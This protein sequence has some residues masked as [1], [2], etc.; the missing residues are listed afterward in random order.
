MFEVEGEPVHLHITLFFFSKIKCIK[1][2]RAFTS[3]LLTTVDTDTT[4]TPI[5]EKA[6]FTDEVQ[7]R[8]RKG[9]AVFLLDVL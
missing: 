2:S 3:A 4:S 1:F 7:S 9:N 6:S 8:K 5:P